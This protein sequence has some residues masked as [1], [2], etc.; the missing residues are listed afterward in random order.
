MTEEKFNEEYVDSNRAR[1]RTVKQWLL[2]YTAYAVLSVLTA[3]AIIL[4]NDNIPLMLGTGFVIFLCLLA[5]LYISRRIRRRNE[6]PK[7]EEC[8][9]HPEDRE[10]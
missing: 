10:K 1:A 3:G 8:G 6:C 5:I 4:F 2:E 9:T 7:E